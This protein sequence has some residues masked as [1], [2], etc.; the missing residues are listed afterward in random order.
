MSRVIMTVMIILIMIVIDMIKWKMTGKPPCHVKRREL[1]IWTVT[2]CAQTGHFLAIM[3][4]R[5]FDCSSVAYAFTSKVT[6]K[7]F[8]LCSFLW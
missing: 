6:K 7:L 3:N 2:M 8:V 5:L 1:E 4:T